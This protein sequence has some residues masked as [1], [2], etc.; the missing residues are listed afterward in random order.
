[1]K[2]LE[3][4]GK[5]FNQE[6]SWAYKKIVDN[7]LDIFYKKAIWMDFN[8]E[9]LVD[10]YFF[11][12]VNYMHEKGINT[13]ISTN[14]AFSFPFALMKNS[15]CKFFKCSVTASSAYCCILESIVV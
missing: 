5:E 6:Y 3:R 7:N 14:G 11:D 2:A 8:G 4:I 13:R 12:R 1:M 15:F 9:P 10:P